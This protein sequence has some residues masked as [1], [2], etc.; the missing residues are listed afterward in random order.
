MNKVIGRAASL[1][2]LLALA[3]VATACG[4]AAG[5]DRAES[6]QQVES[7]MQCHNGAKNDDYSGPGMENPHPFAG[8]DSLTCTECHGGNP[9][10]ADKAASHVPAPPQIGDR[11]QW[12][13]DR[14]AYFNRL[15]LTGIDN[16]PDYQVNGKDYTAMDYL[17]FINPGDLRVVTRQRSCGKCHEAHAEVVAASPLATET[18]ILSG[19][20]H[21]AGIDNAI[22]SQ[23]EDFQR[24][25]A[26]LGFRPVQDTNF[27]A[28]V[29]GT[30]E[31][32][33]EFPV[34]SSRRTATPDGIRN[35]PFY[36]V[37]SIAAV[38]QQHPDGRVIT[39]SAM[40]NLYHE[41]IAFTC[42]DCHLGS[43]GAN[44]RTGD[45]RSSGCAACHMPYAT[46]GRSTSNDPNIN[47][48]E[49]FDPDDIDEPELPHLRRH[50]IVSHAQTLPSGE[51]VQ[52]IDD[53]ACAGCHQGSNRT[54]M[55]FWGIRLDQNQDVRRGFQYPM[56]PKKFKTT[57]GDKRLFGFGPRYDRINDPEQFNREF[58]GRNANQYLLEEDYD[59]DD[60]DDTPPDVHYEA[61]MGCIDCHTSYDL[62]GGDV[63]D[64]NGAKIVSRM[65]H[66]VAIGCE[67]CHGGISQYAATM[68]AKAHD[69]QTASVG[70]DGK[71]NAIKHVV[72]EEDGHYYMYSRLTGKRHFVPQTRDT[73][74]DSGKNHPFN[75]QPLFSAKASYAMGRDDGNPTTGL[76]P[77]QGGIP[78]ING[79]AHSDRMDCASCHASW[80][81]TCMGCHLEGEYSGGNDFS[82]I[83]GEEIVFREEEAQFVYQSPIFF[84]LG[85][86][87]RNKI[88]QT[89]SNTKMF[90]RWKDRNNNRTKTYAFS[91]R[92]SK[93]ANELEAAFP[94]MGHNAMM[95][96]SIR[97]KVSPT[98]EGPRYCVA[99]HMTTEGNAEFG[100]L[101]D[102]FRTAMAT[103]DFASLNYPELAKHF[104]ENTGNHKNS[105][106][107]VHMVAGLG[108]G[109]FLFDED[110]LAVNDLDINPDRYPLNRNITN[111]DTPKSL[112]DPT[113]VKFNLDAIV[114]TDGKANG[115]SNHALIGPIQ[116]PAMRDGSTDPLMTG[117]L[118]ADLIR[119]LTDPG[120]GIV[121]DSWYDSNGDPKGVLAPPP[122]TP[123]Q[124]AP[125]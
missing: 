48:M 22:P 104:G 8:A 114:G 68:T 115:S 52:G 84:Q 107:F 72:L 37:E 116:G 99:C 105:P 58:N 111:G 21:A 40:A 35:N 56:Q 28:S 17:Q 73:I 90:F 63:N 39:G 61:G 43:A 75:G 76:G 78:G 41:Q 49:P 95:A 97:G 47:R 54:V 106:L 109:L 62:H 66:S 85:V 59:G 108:T 50:L 113:R 96:H 6:Q 14:L 30:V 81:N 7:C 18:G 42:G 88:T 2:S 23:A 89:S 34:F 16:F 69:G 103:K 82:N 4:N 125:K 46:D 65:E 60:R 122:P 74:I 92:N 83:T 118:G 124:T 10:G 102:Q 11:A 1:L 45:Y 123:P 121:L 19:A 38:E 86:N 98:K 80:T 13:R 91:G 24:T 36:D 57:A 27:D 31:R 29:F 77:V 67:N 100:V 32:L 64:P 87:S 3:I 112:Y 5:R 120:T 51:A 44:N 79:F 15:T 94:S 110:G 25:A 119:K 55:Q 71:G 33:L 53:Y 117:P 26:D 70:R 101:Y 9:L 20:L 12:E 93:G